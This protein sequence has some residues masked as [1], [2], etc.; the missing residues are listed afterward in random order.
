MG[1]DLKS[2]QEEQRQSWR[3]VIDTCKESGLSIVAFCK[4]EGI[5]QAAYYYWRKKLAV[6][7]ESVPAKQ[8]DAAAGFIQVSMPEI[9]SAGLELV[10]SSGNALRISPGVDYQTLSQVLSALREAGLC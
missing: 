5:S 7:G 4:K 1:K 3:V 9:N 2:S 8:Q 10:L 6:A